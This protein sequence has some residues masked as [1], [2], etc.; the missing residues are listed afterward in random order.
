MRRG[1]EILPRRSGDTDTEAIALSGEDAWLAR[2][3]TV[4]GVRPSGAIAFR[5]KRRPAGYALGMAT[6]RGRT[7]L[8]A[9]R[10]AIALA[11]DGS[12]R[13]R[14]RLPA[15]AR[16]LA[17]GDGVVWAVG[18]RMRPVKVLHRGWTT[19][20]AG[21]GY[22]VALDVETGRRVRALATAPGPSAVAVWRDR[23]WVASPAGLDQL[24][25]T[26]G[27]RLR[28]VASG[29]RMIA[30][31]EGALWWLTYDGSLT[32]RDPGSGERIGDPLPLNQEAVSL[33]TGDGA[34]W[35]G[36]REPGVLRIDAGTMRASWRRSIPPT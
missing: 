33:T 27:R 26:T 34:V 2:S 18:G 24:D 16:D 7:W 1:I 29:A 28:R 32:R 11:D 21:P 10:R 17:G 31:G 4:T 22:A 36:L 3:S 5:E 30:V 12:I 8:A 20:P 15:R 23:L 9:G 19:E 14:P 25:A 13:M 35:V 6:V